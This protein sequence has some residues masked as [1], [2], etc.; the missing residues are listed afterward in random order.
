MKTFLLHIA[1][2]VY[3]TATGQNHTQRLIR[4]KFSNFVRGESRCSWQDCRVKRAPV[5]SAEECER[6]NREAARS[7]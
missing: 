1:G 6:L 2:S 3:E 7:I 4:R 5:P